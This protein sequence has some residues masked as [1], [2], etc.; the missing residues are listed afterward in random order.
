MSEKE[1]RKRRS[2]RKAVRTRAA[3]RAAWKRYVEVDAPSRKGLDALLNHFLR[4]TTVSVRFNPRDSG[5]R[6]KHGTTYG[7]LIAVDGMS[8][9]VQPEGYKRPR[10]YH[11][12]FWEVILP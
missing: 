1:E 10:G 9:I 7:K 11:F 6:L 3:N 2:I 12:G 4:G 8:V 5:L